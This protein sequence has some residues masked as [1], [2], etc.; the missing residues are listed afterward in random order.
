MLNFQPDIQDKVEELFIV[1][2]ERAVRRQDFERGLG[3]V[4]VYLPLPQ[5]LAQ[6]RA[7]NRFLHELYRKA[8]EDR[9]QVEIFFRAEELSAGTT[10]R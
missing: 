1:D 2:C 10:L 4:R 5:T 6:L 8:G 9:K 3:P 7:L